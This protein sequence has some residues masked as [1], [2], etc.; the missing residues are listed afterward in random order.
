MACHE[1]RAGIGRRLVSH[2]DTHRRKV[3]YIAVKD[4]VVYQVRLTGAAHAAP[5]P[6]VEWYG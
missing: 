4:P 1:G 2:S 6:F 3:R 5:V